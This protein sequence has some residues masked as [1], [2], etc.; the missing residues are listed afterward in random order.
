MTTEMPPSGIVD[1][2]VVVT[3]FEDTGVLVLLVV[4]ATVGV[5]LDVSKVVPREVA[6]AAEHVSKVRRNF[7]VAIPWLLRR[8]LSTV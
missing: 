3:F 5:A 7:E 2:N 4:E 6:W 1:V 8:Q